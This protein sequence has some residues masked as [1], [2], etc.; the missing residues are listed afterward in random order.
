MNREW[1]E[2]LS[3]FDASKIRYMIIG[4]HAVMR[5]SE[6]RFTKDL[7]LWIGTDSKN[8]RLVYQALQQFG[9]PL[10]GIGPEDFTKP[11]YFYQMGRPP[12]RVDI[13]MTIPGIEFDEAWK[14][15]QMHPFGPLQVAYISKE[16]LIK[17]KRAAGRLQDLLDL[18]NL[19]KTG[20]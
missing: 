13:V 1:T 4:G 6:P 7:D 2:L 3:L 5:Y 18:Q 12:F 20:L 9:A 14:N 15:R 10:A 17:A 16:D 19:E 11:G 8:A